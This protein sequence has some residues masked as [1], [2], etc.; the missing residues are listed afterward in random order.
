MAVDIQNRFVE[1]SNIP[2]KGALPDVAVNALLIITDEKPIRN[3]NNP[4]FTYQDA[5]EVALDF[6]ASSR[7]AKMLGAIYSQ[8]RSIVTGQGYV[9][10]A[11]AK[12]IQATPPKAV[13]KVLDATVLGT[14][15]IA[16]A[17]IKITVGTTVYEVNGLDLTGITTAQSLV[18]IL[19]NAIPQ[20][21]ITLTGTTSPTI[22]IEAVGANGSKHILAIE[23]G[24]SSVGDLF[25]LLSWTLTQGTDMQANVSDF[26]LI[27][28]IADKTSFQVVTVDMNVDEDSLLTL[29]NQCIAL[30]KELY[31]ILKGISAIDAYAKALAI[32]SDNI[33]LVCLPAEPDSE[34]VIAGAYLSVLCSIDYSGRNTNRTMQ[35]QTLLG[36]KTPYFGN[37]DFDLLKKWGV[38]AYLGIKSGGNVVPAVQSNRPLI[39]Y[40]Q[41]SD[42]TGYGLYSDQARALV[43][44]SLALATAYFNTIYTAPNGIPFIQ[45]GIDIIEGTGRSVCTRGVQNGTIA[46]GITWEGAVPFGDPEDFLSSIRDSGFKVS[47]EPI[48][49]TTKQERTDR[50]QVGNNIAIMLTSYI[51]KVQAVFYYSN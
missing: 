9:V 41:A 40:D 16:D 31:Y 18:D 33:R 43:W 5:T 29:A 15:K 42:S 22:T 21:R 51:H 20:L 38:D 50:V 32:G 4:S 28:K 17:G 24:S 23:K 19:Q 49:N 30:K 36:V 3:V 27:S 45:E 1:V 12:W 6:G 8:P 35:F 13:S 46:P 34:P 7:V 2:S 25:T 48:T 37:S 44:F 26:D 14:L 39:T 47:A 11:P 10:V